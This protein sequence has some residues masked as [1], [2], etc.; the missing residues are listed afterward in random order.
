MPR[1]IVLQIIES[2]VPAN[3]DSLFPTSHVVTKTLLAFTLVCRA[4]HRRARQLLQER[5]IFLNT[6]ERAV[7]YL[8]CLK[9]SESNGSSS[10]DY[11]FP[12]RRIT[13]MMLL[14]A[15]DVEDPEG[16]TPPSAWDLILESQQT[17]RKLLL[18]IPLQWHLSVLKHPLG[19]EALAKRLEGLDRL[20]EFV[21]IDKHWVFDKMDETL[22]FARGERSLWSMWTKLERLLL[23]GMDLEE[24][25]VW[26][27]VVALPRLREVIFAMPHEIYRTNVKLDYSDAVERAAQKGKAVDRGRRLRVMIMEVPY[28]ANDLNTYRWPELDPKGLVTV[29]VYKV[30]TS[31]YG[32]EEDEEVI[33]SWIERGTRTGELWEWRGEVAGEKP[34]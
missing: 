14:P 23:C 10:K 3:P 29:E 28:D 9:L 12:M 31:Y 24:R 16:Q 34:R 5:C 15:N 19:T 18:A 33:L 17:L 22:A 26:D 8:N 21:S 13:A 2:V 30:P 27:N 11:F 32:D 7:R 20:E 1:E 25:S 6:A 4:T